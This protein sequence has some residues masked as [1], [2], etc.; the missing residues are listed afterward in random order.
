MVWMAEKTSVLKTNEINVDSL[1]HL[2]VKVQVELIADKMSAVRNEYKPLKT[3]DIKVPAFS[4]E[5]I[6]VISVSYVEKLLSELNTNKSTPKDDIPVR[7]IKK[8]SNSLSAPLT[9]LINSAIKEGS[10]PKV[11]K[12]EIITPVP[13]V[14]PQKDIDDLRDITGLSPSTK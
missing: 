7:I 1:N 13:K 3:K 14:F 12:E 10:W 9:K 11:F 4:E 2:P 5:D 8:S 6:P